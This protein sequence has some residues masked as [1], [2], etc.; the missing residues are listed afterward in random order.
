MLRQVF[1]DDSVDGR[2]ATSVFVQLATFGR[3]VALLCI[4]RKKTIYA[5]GSVREAGH[6]ESIVEKMSSQIVEAISERHMFSS[7]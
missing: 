6:L 5:R 1:R 3:G 2:Q 7:E 4:I